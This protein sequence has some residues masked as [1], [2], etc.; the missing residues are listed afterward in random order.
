MALASHLLLLPLV[1][2]LKRWF[3]VDAHYAWGYGAFLT[4]LL[5]WAWRRSRGRFVTVSQS[6]ARLDDFLGLQGRLLAA[7]DGVAPWPAPLEGAPAAYRFAFGRSQWA[8]ALA[9]GLFGLAL[10]WPVPVAGGSGLAEARSAPEAWSQLERWLEVMEH[11]ELLKEEAL[12]P[13]EEQLER[14]EAQPP[15]EWYGDASLEASDFLKQQ[16]DLA[17]RA[18]L[19]S[20]QRASFS[21]TQIAGGATGAARSSYDRRLEENL[22][23]LELGTLP[24]REDMMK[25]LSEVARDGGA[26]MDEKALQSL[27]DKMREGGETCAR[28]LGMNS[29]E[30]EP[31]DPG[32]LALGEGSGDGGDGGGPAPLTFRG[33]ASPRLEGRAEGLSNDDRT[34][35]LLGDA[36]FSSVMR[37]EDF[38]SDYQGREQAY[39]AEHEGLGGDAVWKTRAR[40]DEQELLKAYFS[41]D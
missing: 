7:Q 26:S 25:A 9:L 6:L 3:P 21:A 32:S 38:Q 10:Y 40:P 28:G 39:R 23:N 36:A 24:L 11:V 8:L 31:F 19:D 4:V 27:L 20:L 22:E 12:R 16:A 35:A 14:L 5:A 34:R 18:F 33:E 37:A 1:L 2:W 41:H 13:F 15:S 17:T 29:L 30:L